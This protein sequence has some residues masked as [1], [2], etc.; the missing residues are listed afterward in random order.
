MASLLTKSILAILGSVILI[1]L[2][3][4]CMFLFCQVII[5][6]VLVAISYVIAMFGYYYLGKAWN[7]TV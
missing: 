7:M 3:F 6:S 1:I 2:G 4:V 5:G